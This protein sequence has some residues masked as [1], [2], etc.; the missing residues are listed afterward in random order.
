MT[1][2]LSLDKT[3]VYPA[4]LVGIRI[5]P[6]STAVFPERDDTGGRV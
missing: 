2:L 4:C 1:S 5:L 3:I 6:N